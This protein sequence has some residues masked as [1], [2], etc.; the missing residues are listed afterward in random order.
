MGR[1]VFTFKQFEIKQNK[2]AMKVGTDAVLLGSW[3]NLPEKGNTLDIGTG[4]GI[5]ALMAA[6][7]SCTFIDAIEIDEDAYRQASENCHNSKWKDRV[8]VHHISF[9]RFVPSVLKQYDV[10]IS[11]PP[12]FSN[13]LKAASEPRTMARHTHTLSFEELVDGIAQL[14][15]K[16][17]LFA[18]ILPLKEASDLLAIAKRYGLYLNKKM[19]VKTTI[20]KPAKRVLMEF[21]FTK[22]PPQEETLIIENE[23]DGSKI[24]IRSYSNEYK[25]LTQDFYIGG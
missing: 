21:C 14:L 19:S 25:H 6:Q 2:C 8:Q 5:I 22:S 18:T 1:D 20:S 15:K 23:P 3:C 12:Y 10:I 13:S 9:Q 11:N 16:D 17:G 4:T 24:K 7:R